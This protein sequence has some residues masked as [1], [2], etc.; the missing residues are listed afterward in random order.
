M[1]ITVAARSKARVCSSSFPGI[2]GSNPAGAW[3]SVCLSVVHCRVERSLSRADH[4]SRGV[5]PTV[6]CLSV[7]EE[8][9]QWGGPGP[10][11]AVGP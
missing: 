5:P 6:M 10:L 2:A 9:Q 11:G 8:H 7:I 4:S 1:L 3:M